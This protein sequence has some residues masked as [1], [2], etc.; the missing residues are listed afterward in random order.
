M[1]LFNPGA[2][3]PLVTQPLAT[4]LED[5]IPEAAGLIRRNVDF[6]AVFACVA[7]ARDSSGRS[8]DRAIGEVIAAHGREI[9]RGEL[10]QDVRAARALDGELRVT[11]TRVLN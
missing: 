2:R 10:L 3:P 9:G 6:P 4:R 5:F 1:F 8:R 11:R 7:G